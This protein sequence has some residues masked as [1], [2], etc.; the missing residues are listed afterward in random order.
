MLATPE[1]SSFSSIIGES[2]DARPL[3]ASEYAGGSTFIAGDGELIWWQET[4]LIHCALQCTALHF[5]IVLKIR[6]ALRAFRHVLQPTKKKK[7]ISRA[8][9]LTPFTSYS[10]TVVD[11]VAGAISSERLDDGVD[12]SI[13]GEDDFDEVSLSCRSEVISQP[14]AT[15]RTLHDST[16]R[17]RSLAWSV[18]AWPGLL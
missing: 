7:H 5:T 16:R 11:G 12:G 9:A 6:F 3:R 15:R 13:F 18:W 2:A 1:L 10:S 4:L 8:G 14:L 17:L